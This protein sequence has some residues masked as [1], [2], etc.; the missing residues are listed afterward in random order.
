MK[1][2]NDEILGLVEILRLPAAA[3]VAQAAMHSMS[4]LSKFGRHFGLSNVVYRQV[5]YIGE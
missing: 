2:D 5:T 1:I 3:L 4:Y